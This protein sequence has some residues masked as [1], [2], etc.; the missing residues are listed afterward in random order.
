MFQFGTNHC[1]SP[2]KIE[3]QE[4]LSDSQARVRMEIVPSKV[5]NFKS[6]KHIIHHRAM[7]MIYTH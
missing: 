7:L 2:S 6:L 5:P 1:E 3:L 4:D